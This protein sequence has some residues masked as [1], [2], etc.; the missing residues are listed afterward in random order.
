MKQ[1]IFVKNITQKQYFT[2]NF[3][4]LQLFYDLWQPNGYIQAVG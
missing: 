4:A 1:Y 3:T 2:C